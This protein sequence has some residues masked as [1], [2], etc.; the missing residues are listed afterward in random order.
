MKLKTYQWLLIIIAFSLLL[1]LIFFTGS[2]SSD[3]LEYYKFANQANHGAFEL[4]ADHFKFRV[5]TFYPTALFFR[6]FGVNE[7]S[8]N[9]LT[10]LTSI[11]GIVLIYFLGTHFFNEKAGLIAAFLLS[12]YPLDVVY[13]TRLLPDIPSAFFMGL[14]V[15]LFLY[16]EKYRKKQNAYYLFS[17]IALGIAYLIKEVSL[18]MGLFFAAYF[19]YKKK[20]KLNYLL[21]GIGLGAA[22]LFLMIYS[23]AHSGDPF[24]QYKANEQQQI[25]FMKAL[26]KNYFTT[27]G[28]ISR[29]FLHYPYYMLTDAHYGLF[30]IFVGVSILYFLYRRKEETYV[31]IIWMLSLLL[32]L[33]FGTISLKQYVPF[34]VI[35]RHLSIITFPALVLVAYFIE[36]FEYPSK[37]SKFSK[38][39]LNQNGKIMGY[40]KFSITEIK[41]KKLN[42]LITGLLLFSSLF[43]IYS[44]HLRHDIDN[45]RLAFNYISNNP[46]KAVYTD[47]RTYRILD[48]LFEFKRSDVLP[49]NNYDYY[50]Y[51]NPNKNLMIMELKKVKNSYIVINSDI[52]ARLPLTYSDM[53]FPREI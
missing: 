32:Y 33:N 13:A 37:L 23:Y 3:E 22:I 30:F 39:T 51:E 43:F 4:G 52:L 48:Y 24:F 34:P 18:I 15:L 50:N 41:I 20:F 16:G 9:L 8:G 11:F 35:I 6:I 10:L 38:R 28:L 45:V 12:F 44:S 7:F 2:D 14:G 5:G 53:K 27:Q 19:I 49:F 40:S 29:L 46:E 17:G 21:L 26:Y 36:N 31:P 25:G 42:A 1:R 47:E